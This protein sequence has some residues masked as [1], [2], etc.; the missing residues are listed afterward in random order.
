MSETQEAWR[1]VREFVLRGS[2]E[3]G[4]Y[5]E[6]RTW[7][8]VFAA[9]LAGTLNALVRE[10][11]EAVR[12]L[13]YLES[14]MEESGGHYCD[15][16][17]MAWSDAQQAISDKDEAV[18]RAE[19]LAVALDACETALAPVMVSHDCGDEPRPGVR[20][21]ECLGCGR[22]AAWEMARKALTPI[23]ASSPEVGKEEEW[24]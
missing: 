10:R 1:T 12:K 8:S 14:M 11:D 22:W 24:T 15:G 21:G 3:D 6:F 20:C 18:R 7:S 5:E 4:N 19:E 2:R 16:M 17:S 9:S 23:K 13:A